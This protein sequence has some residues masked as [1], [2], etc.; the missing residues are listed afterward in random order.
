M[1]L[2]HTESIVQTCGGNF[3]TLFFALITSIVQGWF[4]YFSFRDLKKL[5]SSNQE[6]FVIGQWTINRITQSYSSTSTDEAD[7]HANKWRNERR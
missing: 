6:E 4:P 3:E 7:G 5:P 1:F 2:V